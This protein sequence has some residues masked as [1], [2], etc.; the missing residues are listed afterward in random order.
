MKIKK[1]FPLPTMVAAVAGVVIVVAAMVFSFN[2]ARK[3]TIVE[4]KTDVD[5]RVAWF[6]KEIMVNIEALYGIKGLY[7]SSEKVTRGEFNV[8]ATSILKRLNAIKALEWI[9][10]VNH[11]ERGQFETHIRQE[12]FTDFQITERVEQN[13]MVRAKNRNEY[14]PV[15]FVEPY[16]GNEKA[17]GFDLA[18]NLKR[19]QALETSRETGKLVITESITLVQEKG[20]GKGFLAVLPVYKNGE[21]STNGQ[22]G[23]LHGFVLGVYRIDDIFDLAIQ[24]TRSI[25]LGIDMKLIDV[26]TLGEEKMFFYHESRT[27]FKAMD[28]F[29]YYK[30]LS[31]IGG[32]R[33]KVA[34]IP[35][36]FYFTQRQSKR[37]YAILIVGLIFTVLLSVYIQS[38][39][40]RTEKIKT[41]VIFRTA[42]LKASETKVRAIVET[43]TNAIITIDAKGT[44]ASFNPASEKIFG[45]KAKDV[46][47]CNVKMLMP[48]PDKTKH[49]GYLSKYLET[50][51]KNV[52]GI[53]REVVGLRKDGTQFPAYL[54]VSEMEIDGS[55][56][57]VGMVIDITERKNAEK[58]LRDNEERLSLVLNGVNLGMWDW[59]V[60]TGHLTFNDRLP[61]MLGYLPNEFEPDVKEWKSRI[62]PDDLPKVMDTLNAH[63]AGKTPFYIKEHRLKTKSA[64]WKWILDSGK[65]VAWNENK[66][67]TRMVGIHM[68][69]NDRK[70]VEKEL[71]Q[72]RKEAQLASKAK[73]EFLA[74]MSHE[75]RTPMN[76]IIGMAEVLSETPLNEEQ[77]KY[78]DVFKGAGDALLLLINDILDF[79]KIEAGQIE[80]EN[81]PFY[82][83]PLLN[84][85]VLI[86]EVNSKIK[87]IKIICD[88]QNSV[89]DVLVGDPTRLR[90]IIINLIGNSLKFTEKGSITLRVQND[91][92]DKRKGSLLFSVIDTGVG[93]P[94]EKQ[95]TIF[96]NFS[97][98]DSSVTRKYGGTG[99]GLAISK[100]LIE[101][102]DGQICV[103]SELGK[104]CTFHFTCKFT[105]PLSDT[106]TSVISTTIDQTIDTKS[107]VGKV[108]KNLP[109]LNI[110]LVEDNSDNRMLAM[111]YLKNTPFKV[112]IAENGQIAVDKFKSNEY[113]LVLMDIQM[114]V[115]D[116]YTAT[117]EIRTWETTKSLP[118]TPIIALSAHALK[119]EEQ[120]S[121]NAGCDGHI[122][123]P[124]KKK[125][126]IE[127][128]CNFAKNKA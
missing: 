31:T 102:M 90:Q 22:G 32:R 128:I 110:L 51:K 20:K 62:H 3:K 124:I 18:S 126:L 21:V 5:A 54:S 7:D 14:F 74:R 36:S 34:A 81:T 79:S 82:L 121:L 84:E 15:S 68:D 70:K 47:G 77:K 49:D 30:T 127:T 109:N 99:L 2:L 19:R 107:N 28:S 60:V 13:E 52:I 57:F 56:M 40:S 37:P 16:K 41:I 65:V 67:P 66:K 94:K 105:E 118:P 59:D 17:F 93:I 10:Y 104:G 33:W 106:H 115:M 69:I 45:Y 91:P 61:E 43:V 80:L 11:S 76:A 9:P 111:A 103:E 95:K 8:F 38:L 101:L 120:K 78:I 55:K 35:N 97:Q 98:A 44:I 89:P 112:D 27:G 86:M 46:I 71:V 116:G 48:V 108:P 72:S 87:G 113:H 64:D 119:E 6:E 96:E 88:V 125:L 12:G 39:S 42:E 122:T 114:P 73:S 1:V 23:E 100:K 85:T 75:I 53:G 25:P 92:D 50:G 123:K 63:F 24:K 117:N 58:K 29:V 83:K 26:T 4:F